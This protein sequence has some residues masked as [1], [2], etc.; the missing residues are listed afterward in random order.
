MAPFGHNIAGFW[1]LVLRQACQSVLA[2]PEMYL[3][4]NA[5]VIEQGRNRCPGNDVGVGYAD[6][7]CHDEGCG[8]H[9]W[10]QQL[11]AYGSGGFNSAGEFLGIA[12]FFHQGNGEGAG[13]NHVGYRGTVDGTEKT[14]SDDRHFCRAAF[15][16]AC[17]GQG[18]IVKE[19][20]HAALVHD[21]AEQDE[22]ED[23]AGG[24]ADRGAVD[25][26]RVGKEMVGQG[27]PVIAPVHEHA[28]EFPAEKTVHDKD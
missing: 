26:F 11:S 17:Q 6:H 25:T 1:K 28:G 5:Q 2:G 24:N 8:A 12:G 14:G 10:R 21:R 20:A 22:Q 16:V 27:R 4:D 13:S 9:N 19:L 7:F 23:V 15:G 3:D 18:D